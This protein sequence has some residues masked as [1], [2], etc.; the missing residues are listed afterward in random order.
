[1]SKNTPRRQFQPDFRLEPKSR[2]FQP[3][4]RLEPKSIHNTTENIVS[5]DAAQKNTVADKNTVL[6]PALPRL[7]TPPQQARLLS[8][9]G[10]VSPHQFMSPV[11]ES[12][13]SEPSF[14]SANLPTRPSGKRRWGRSLLI[15]VIVAGMLLTLIFG[16]LWLSSHADADVT[17]FQ[18]QAQR[19]EQVVGGGGIVYPH[20]Q[21]NI[22][23]PMAERV[24]AV[25][26]HEGDQV[27]PDQAL[28]RLDTTQLNAQMKQA[29]GNIVAAQDYLSTVSMSGN[30]VTIAQAQQ[31]LALAKNRYAALVAQSEY[32]LTHAGNL[33]SPLRGVVTAVNIS[34]GE[35]LTPHAV[36]LVIMDESALVVHM[37]VPLENVGQV[38]V[39]AQAQVTSSAFA[40]RSFSGTVSAVIPQ[41]NPQTNT[42]E[43]W[44]NVNDSQHL[45]LPGMSTFV[46]ILL[47]STAVVVPRLSVMALANL[48]VVFV[49]RGQ[50]AY[51][52][53]VQ[54][55]GR[56][57]DR[58][59]VAT[60]LKHGEYIVLVGL[61]QLSDGQS[62]HVRAIEQ[63][64]GML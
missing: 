51:L 40:N 56:N 8:S 25:L 42:F 45:L 2:Q 60:G 61:D 33:I 57:E 32:P 21:L 10:P 43:V 55:M 20:Q 9:R 18:V 44:V 14:S 37:Q 17:L 63:S 54:I 23:Y 3:G 13:L 22:T 29:E 27:V 50:H 28:L 34:A 15:V 49:V 26:V 64:G 41:A 5:F 62:V 48:M 6:L 1:M 7:F 52:R 36:L 53:I 47:P 35:A 46:R 16:S 12:L 30:A 38:R 39:G 11:P 58:L 31:Q 19:S 24:L 4:F 59:F